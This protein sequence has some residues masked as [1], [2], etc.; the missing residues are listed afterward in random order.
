MENEENIN[1]G[2]ELSRKERK[3]KKRE[4]R[5]RQRARLIYVKKVKKISLWF[6]ALVALAAFVYWGVITA[7]NSEEK[8]P[9]ERA[10]IVGRDH[11]NVGDEHDPY[12]T[13]PPTSGAHSAPVDFGVYEEELADENVIHNL[14][15]GG[16]WISYKD[17]DKEDIKKLED[18][19]RKY[20]G[21]TV[22]SPRSANDSTI[23]VASWGRLLKLDEVDVEQITEYV[24]QNV[25]KSPEPLAK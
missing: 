8:R 10:S 14:E 16:I 9:G 20:P 23:A 21:R 7:K 4:E 6:F 5:E 12:N 3:E 22:V 13:N 15:H 1:Q 19:G 17:L 24:K 2:H 25:N 11:I 18:I